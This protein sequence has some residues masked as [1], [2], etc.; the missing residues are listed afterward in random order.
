MNESRLGLVVVAVMALLV[1]SSRATTSPSPPVNTVACNAS[2]MGV[3]FSGPLR[4]VSV[5]SFGCV[6]RW[7]YVWATVGHGVS[8]VGVTEVVR[9]SDRLG[10]WTFASR[11]VVCGHHVLPGYVQYWGCNSN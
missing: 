7:G 10:R 6:G 1:A 8:E 11:A 3:A 2:A 9:F 5:Q 4:L